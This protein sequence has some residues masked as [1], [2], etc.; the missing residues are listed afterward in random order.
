[1]VQNFQGGSAFMAGKSLPNEKGVLQVG[2][3]PRTP[4]IFGV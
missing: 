4:P 2:F 1:M 3:Q